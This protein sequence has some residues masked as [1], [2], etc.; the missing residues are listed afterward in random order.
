LGGPFAGAVHG[1]AHPAGLFGL[2]RIGQGQGQQAADLVVRAFVDQAVNPLGAH[3]A[4]RRVMHQHPVLRLGA[5]GTQLVQT[6]G[7]GF[8]ACGTAHARHPGLLAGKA[9]RVFLELVVV[10]GQHHQRGRQARHLGQSLQGVGDHG[11]TRNGLVLLGA[12]R[13][14]PGAGAGTG[15]QGK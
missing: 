11:L 6:V 9:G 1:G 10:R 5:A 8:G 3:Q 13:A 14:G 15:H 12:Q 2:E 4:A 7:H